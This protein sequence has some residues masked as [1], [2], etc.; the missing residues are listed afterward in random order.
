MDS[1]VAM[2]TLKAV[3]GAAA[4]VHTLP[5]TLLTAK[6]TRLMPSPTNMYALVP[7]AA[8]LSTVSVPSAAPRFTA[9][10]HSVSAAPS[11]KLF[12]SP[13]MAAKNASRWNG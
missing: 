12:C 10:L 7:N 9:R 2:P 8:P 3:P 11:Q 5:A 6:G 13:P 4:S 1:M